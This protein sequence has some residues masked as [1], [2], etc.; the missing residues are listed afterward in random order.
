MTPTTAASVVL[1]VHRVKLAP[2][3]SANVP[4]VRPI[5]V[6]PALIPVAT[7]TTVAPVVMPAHRVKLAPVESVSVPPDRRSVVESASTP[8]VI[9]TTDRLSGGTDTDS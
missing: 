9:T 1:P 4:P 8:V 6:G 3:G 7:P 5:V 2:V